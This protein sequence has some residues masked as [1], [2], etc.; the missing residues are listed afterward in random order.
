MEPEASREVRCDTEMRVKS[1]DVGAMQV[2]GPR[3]EGHD[4]LTLWCV[5]RD[6][7]PV[8]R[9]NRPFLAMAQAIPQQKIAEVK[10][11]IQRRT[12]FYEVEHF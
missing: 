6:I 5:G 10:R 12:V 2:R 9:G 1:G 7:H 4:E 8:L 11:A 3:L